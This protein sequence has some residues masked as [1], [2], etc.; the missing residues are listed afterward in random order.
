VIEQDAV[1]RFADAPAII[2]DHIDVER[3]TK[4]LGGPDRRMAI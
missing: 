2:N 4:E 1:N 3:A